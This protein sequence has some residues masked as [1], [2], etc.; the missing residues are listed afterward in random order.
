M[1]SGLE[2]MEWL[3]DSFEMTKS[4]EMGKLKCEL[5]WRRFGMVFGE[6]IVC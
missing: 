5:K 6:I 1:L 3:W 2:V 4:V